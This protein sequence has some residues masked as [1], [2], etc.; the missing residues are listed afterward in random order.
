MPIVNFRIAVEARKDLGD[1]SK[2][3]SVCHIL[4]IGVTDPNS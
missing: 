1:L 4:P 2:N 3:G